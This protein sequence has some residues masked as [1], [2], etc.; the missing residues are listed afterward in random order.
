MKGLKMKIS[1]EEIRKLEEM[2]ENYKSKHGEVSNMP[3]TL[4]CY[5]GANCTC[6]CESYCDGNG[7]GG[8]NICW[9]SGAKR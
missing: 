7:K 3:D 5:C 8:S 2:L 4:N 1:N 6:T 9:Q